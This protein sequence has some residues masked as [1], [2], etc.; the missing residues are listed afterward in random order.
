M[1]KYD[2]KNSNSILSSNT[3]NDNNIDIN[4]NNLSQP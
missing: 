3:K 4:H 2:R 1:G